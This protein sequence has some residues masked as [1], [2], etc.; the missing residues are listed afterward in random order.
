MKKRRSEKG[1]GDYF[2][3]ISSG[4][5][6]EL[7]LGYNTCIPHIMGDID[8]RELVVREVQNLFVESLLGQSFLR[9]HFTSRGVSFETDGV[10]FCAVYPEPDQLTGGGVYVSHNI[11]TLE[12]K[13]VLLGALLKYLPWLFQILEDF[14]SGERDPN[15]FP[16]LEKEERFVK[17]IR[18]KYRKDCSISE[19]LGEK[20]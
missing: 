8:F 2:P 16:S 10:N 13:L 14:E 17:T 6:V 1:I 11:D 18:T 19:F 9:L 4:I 12:Q 3:N 5:K 15:D 7:P 20:S